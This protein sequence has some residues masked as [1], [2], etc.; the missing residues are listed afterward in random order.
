VPAVF[1]ENI[2]SGDLAEILAEETGTDV[3]VV[4]LVS[5]ALGE[6]GSETGSYLDML[7]YNATAIADALDGQD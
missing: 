2:G 4:E 6:P 5:D 7:L 1:V 3:V